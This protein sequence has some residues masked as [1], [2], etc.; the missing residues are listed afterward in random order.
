M[1]GCTCPGNLTLTVS[2]PSSDSVLLAVLTWCVFVS[3]WVRFWTVIV[4]WKC[5]SVPVCTWGDI[6]PLD[7]L[8]HRTATAGKRAICLQK[9]VYINGK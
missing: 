9:H 6:S 3:Q 5:L 8:S 2:P 4:V 1:D 7:P